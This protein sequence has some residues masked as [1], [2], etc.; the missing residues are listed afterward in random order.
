MQVKNYTINYS[1]HHVFLCSLMILVH[2]T[3]AH[4]T[5]ASLFLCQGICQKDEDCK[6][7]LVCFHRDKWNQM[8]KECAGI[9]TLDSNFCIRHGSIFPENMKHSRYCTDTCS[10]DEPCPSHFKCMNYYGA[11]RYCTI[12]EKDSTLKYCVDRRYIL[13]NEKENIHR[14]SLKESSSFPSKRKVNFQS[15]IVSNFLNQVI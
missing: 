13:S 5:G 2:V 15:E 10:S 4:S 8:P 9:T 11:S 12:A 7:D 14:S 3:I 1:H 6:D